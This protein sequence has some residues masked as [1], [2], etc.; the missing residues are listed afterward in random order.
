[1]ASA[2]TEPFMGYCRSP[3]QQRSRKSMKTCPG[4][5]STKSHQDQPGGEERRQV[6]Q[7]EDLQWQSQGVMKENGECVRKVKVVGGLFPGQC[8]TCGMMRPEKTK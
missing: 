3:G 8:R 5:Q 4:T 7:A 2:L 6:F 1:M